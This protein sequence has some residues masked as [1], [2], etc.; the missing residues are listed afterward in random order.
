MKNETKV[1]WWWNLPV[2]FMIV[3]FVSLGIRSIVTDDNRYGWGTFSKQVVYEVDYFWVLDNGKRIRYFPGDELLKGSVEKLNSH[4]NTRYSI[5]A[6]K[7]WVNNYISYVYL[8]KK[9]G[10]EVTSFIAEVEYVINISRRKKWYTMEDDKI[11]KIVIE[12]PKKRNN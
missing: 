11:H 2:F 6:V 10:P 8:N 9:P 5:G 3:L 1:K 4:G 7:S 12:Y